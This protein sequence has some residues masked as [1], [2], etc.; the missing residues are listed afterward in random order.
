M[1]SDSQEIIPEILLLKKKTV[2]EIKECE[3]A[4]KE[5]RQMELFLGKLFSFMQGMKL[6]H[7]LALT[8]KEKATMESLRK[9]DFDSFTSLQKALSVIRSEAQTAIKRFPRLFQM[10][11]EEAGLVI[12]ESSIHPRYSFYDDFFTVEINES[13]GTAII[14]DRMAKLHELPCD[15][16][17][18]I[19]L[20]K[21][22]HK[23]VFQRP[24]DPGRFLKKLFKYYSDQI[25]KEKKSMGDSVAIASIINAFKVK[26]RSFKADEFLYDL[27]RLAEGGSQQI[28]G[29]LLDFQHTKD[30]ESGILLY[31]HESGGYIGYILFRRSTNA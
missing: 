2:D 20:I 7:I 19:A 24:F 15:I 29:H 17:E 30:T 21:E 25:K 4:L 27:S 16:S 9:K 3:Q 13:K 31:K 18:I 23:R 12:D 26:D 8:Q 14:R 28:D 6:Q 10:A 1:E 5:L 11:C 22:E